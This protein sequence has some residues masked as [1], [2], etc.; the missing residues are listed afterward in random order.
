MFTRDFVRL[1]FEFRTTS[2]TISIEQLSNIRRELCTHPR[3]GLVRTMY[4]GVACIFKHPKGAL[5]SCPPYHI[6]PLGI[7]GTI[8]KIYLRSD[9]KVMFHMSVM[10]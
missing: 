9:G 7:P 4:I 3:C 8:A 10:G 2:I 5:L 1:S 6:P